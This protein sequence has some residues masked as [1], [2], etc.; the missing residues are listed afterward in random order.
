MSF[1]AHG[2]LKDH[3]KKHYNIRPYI[4][5]IC[6]QKFSRNS[7]LKMH[8]NTHVNTKPF[9]CPE[10]NCDKSFVDKAQIKF[11]MKNHHENESAER[12]NEIFKEY[13][14]TCGETIKNLVAER[15]KEISRQVEGKAPVKPELPKFIRTEN[16]YKVITYEEQKREESGMLINY[17]YRIEKRLK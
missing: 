6:G 14:K 2:H 3:M 12:F 13:L 11:H 15:E 16:S 10:Q 7:T 9:I 5:S 1:K 8:I 4:C 17:K